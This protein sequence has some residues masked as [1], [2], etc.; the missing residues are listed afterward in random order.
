[1]LLFNFMLMLPI[2]MTADKIFARLVRVIDREDDTPPFFVLKFS[3]NSM[4]FSIVFFVIA[5]VV[6]EG[7]TYIYTQVT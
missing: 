2:L 4:F 7:K 3:I 5:G 1:M 6:L